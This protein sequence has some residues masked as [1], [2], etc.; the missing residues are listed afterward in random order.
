M[1]GTGYAQRKDPWSNDVELQ[2]LI[3]NGYMYDL[4]DLRE[5]L[6]RFILIWL[7][8]LERTAD[9][10]F[11]RPY[12]EEL[13]SM[14][15]EPVQPPGEKLVEL[16]APILENLER[17]VRQTEPG[18]PADS[19]RVEYHVIEGCVLSRHTEA[20]TDHPRWVTMCFA[21]GKQT[22]AFLLALDFEQIQG[23]LRGDSC[24]VKMEDTNDTDVTFSDVLMGR[25]YPYRRVKMGGKIESRHDPNVNHRLLKDRIATGVYDPV[26][27]AR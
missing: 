14:R 2:I 18:A 4:A 25:M 19:C 20:L 10:S 6:T 7:A 5:R 27:R 16:P 21:E 12:D 8:Q 15:L 22:P 17:Y 13:R 9:S 26:G 24:Y 1:I 3:E 11:I 23:Y